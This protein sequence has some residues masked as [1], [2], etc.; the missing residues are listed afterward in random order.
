MDVLMWPR[1]FADDV[2]KGWYVPPVAALGVPYLVLGFP[3][4][5]DGLMPIAQ[6]WLLAGAVLYVGDMILYPQKKQ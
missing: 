3:N 4:L 1:E 2:G 5:N 6:W